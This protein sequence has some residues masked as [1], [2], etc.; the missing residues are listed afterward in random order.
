MYS[1]IES[2]NKCNANGRNEIRYQIWWGNYEV[3]YQHIAQRDIMAHGG[4]GDLNLY[5]GEGQAADKQIVAITNKVRNATRV[6]V[7]VNWSFTLLRV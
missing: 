4:Q 7:Q 3:I 2:W 6:G 1:A 5:R